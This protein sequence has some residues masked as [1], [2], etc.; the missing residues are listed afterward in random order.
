M[1]FTTAQRGIEKLEE[2]GILTKISRGKR[3]K[4][5]CANEILSILEEST[6]ITENLDGTLL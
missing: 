4:V 2:L 6:K 3:D 5:Y 1:A